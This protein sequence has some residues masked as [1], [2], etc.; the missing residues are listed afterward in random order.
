MECRIRLCKPH[1]R[2]FSSFVVHKVYT[3][4][5][6]GCQ[7]FFLDSLFLFYYDKVYS[8]KRILYFYES[9]HIAEAFR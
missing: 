8:E 1:V 4:L 6:M 9:R 2:K 7:E 3:D 5:H